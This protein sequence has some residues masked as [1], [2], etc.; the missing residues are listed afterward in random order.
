MQTKTRKNG[1]K[2]PQTKYHPKKLTQRYVIMV[3]MNTI[4]N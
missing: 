2:Q 1:G 4:M 3:A